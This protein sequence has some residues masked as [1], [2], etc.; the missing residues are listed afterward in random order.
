[1]EEREHLV[2]A[3]LRPAE[4][5]P[6]RERPLDVGREDLALDRVEIAAVEAVVHL[7]DGLHRRRLCGGQWSPFFVIGVRGSTGHG[8]RRDARPR[9]YD[10]HAGRV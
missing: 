2:G 8:R 4:R 1:M 6:T 7:L 5:M 3:V 9:V 10:A